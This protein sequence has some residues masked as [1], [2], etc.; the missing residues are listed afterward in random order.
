MSAENPDL[1]FKLWLP[2][3][4]GL[5]THNNVSDFFGEHELRLSVFANLSPT[6]PITFI[7]A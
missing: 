4:N 3:K 6:L 2:S 7:Q 5:P 1:R